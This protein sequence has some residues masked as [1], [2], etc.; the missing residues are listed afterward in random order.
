MSCLLTQFHND[1]VVLVEVLQKDIEWIVDTV[2]I[3]VD[4]GSAIIAHIDIVL[5]DRMKSLVRSDGGSSSTTQKEQEWL[6]LLLLLLRTAIIR[7]EGKS[8][9]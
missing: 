7:R 4:N 2:W 9:C 8:C 3:G 1:E 5:F 6:L